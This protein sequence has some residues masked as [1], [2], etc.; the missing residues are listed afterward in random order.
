[1]R[2]SE[3]EIADLERD[4]ARLLER[5]ETERAGRLKAERTC[6]EYRAQIRNIQEALH[7]AGLI[8]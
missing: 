4:N 7:R 2:N 5:A 3:Q 8:S 1:M 6:S